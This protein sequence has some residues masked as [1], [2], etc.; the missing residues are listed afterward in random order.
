MT[1]GGALAVADLLAFLPAG[2]RKGQGETRGQEAGIVGKM[3][4]AQSTRTGSRCHPVV[5]GA[6]LKGVPNKTQ[7]AG[8]HSR[9][10]SGFVG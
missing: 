9:S 10:T 1:N 7:E 5:A 2:V 8:L 6:P 3:A 4:M